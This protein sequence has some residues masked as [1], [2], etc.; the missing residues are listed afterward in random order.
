MSKGRRGK[1]RG[2]RSDYA[3]ERQRGRTELFS[4]LQIMFAQE[5]V[6]K[7]RE[8]A[9]VVFTPRSIPPNTRYTKLLEQGEVLT[10]GVAFTS[11]LILKLI[12]E[13]VV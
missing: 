11:P 1:P 10:R 7:D 13:A 9:E 12:R 4:E 6:T 8:N 3:K 5:N 2:E